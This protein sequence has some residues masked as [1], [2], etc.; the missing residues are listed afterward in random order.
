MAGEKLYP[1]RIV[2]FVSAW[3]KKWGKQYPYPELWEYIKDSLTLEEAIGDP[4]KQVTLFNR[5]LKQFEDLVDTGKIKIA[6]ETPAA[7]TPP[8]GTLPT[9]T[10]EDELFQQQLQQLID[11]GKLSREQFEWGKTQD[12]WQRGMTERQLA[13][14]ESQ[15]ASQIQR[16]KYEA[17]K[18]MAQAWYTQFL[19]SLQANQQEEED[20]LQSARNKAYEEGRDLTIAGLREN[21]P[22]NWLKIS[23]VQA[24]QN[25]YQPR[26]KTF[27]PDINEY[28][29]YLTQQEKTIK[30]QI[31]DV[32]DKVNDPY[33]P[34]LKGDADKMIAEL[35]A[36]LSGIKDNKIQNRESILS[37]YQSSVNKMTAAGSTPYTPSVSNWDVFGSAARYV[38][39]PEASEFSGIPTELAQSYGGMIGGMMSTA[40]QQAQKP[41]AKYVETPAWLQQYGVGNRITMGE[42]PVNAITPSGQSYTR[43]NPEQ[44]EML[45]GYYD[46]SGQGNENMM[47]SMYNQLPQPLNLGRRWK[48]ARSY[49]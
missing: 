44:R 16:E 21:Q 46:Y 12:L 27:A 39:N 1:K 19:A 26:Q 10:P 30:D 6:G 40:Y 41:P 15:Y 9:T 28:D 7:E 34:L 43:L 22:M 17:Q 4:T 18:S 3:Q 36:M 33:D 31:K 11:E 47:W 38:Q 20:A 8:E 29:E 24:M 42:T 35:R 5:Y 25:P 14:Q 2:D 23:Q 48:S 13:S 49:V 45:A 37:P 32:E